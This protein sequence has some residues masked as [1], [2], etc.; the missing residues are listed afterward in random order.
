MRF[1]DEAAP[2]TLFK[3]DCKKLD[4]LFALLEFCEENNELKLF[5]KA[6]SGEPELLPDEGVENG[7]LESVPPL[8]EIESN[9]EACAL[10]TLLLT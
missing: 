8:P 4:R 2:W 10:A 9:M 7:S 5:C 3:V 1:P 6:S